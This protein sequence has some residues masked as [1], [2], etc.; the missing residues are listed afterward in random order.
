MKMIVTGSVLRWRRGIERA[1]NEIHQIANSAILAF[2]TG[3]QDGGVLL[4]ST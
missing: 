3:L 2:A 1:R 4:S